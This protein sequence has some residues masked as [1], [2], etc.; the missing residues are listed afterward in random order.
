MDLRDLYGLV[1]VY[2]TSR[3][4]DGSVTL[5]LNDR[6][7]ELGPNEFGAY[8]KLAEWLPTTRPQTELEAALRM[9]SGRLTRFVAMLE[10]AGVVYST[11]RIPERLTGEAFH[12]DYFS[13]FLPSWLGEAFSHP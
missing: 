5:Q 12:R 8:T 13:K 3:A 2:G 11:A 9:P 1:R 6:A 7:V 10:R 4:T